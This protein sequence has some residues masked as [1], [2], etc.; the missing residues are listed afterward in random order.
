MSAALDEAMQGQGTEEL[1]EQQ[2][3]QVESQEG[4][5]STK[6]QQKEP[7]AK[8]ETAG[9]S[10]YQTQTEAEEEAEE[11][12]AKYKAKYLETLKQKALLDAGF[13]FGQ[14]PTYERYIS[15]ETV[16]EIEQQA[17]ELAT[18]VSKKPKYTDPSRKRSGWNPFK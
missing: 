7:G 3:E 18:E 2:G 6:S 12:Q 9:E 8:E 17:T 1:T 5:E 4:T 15:G 16:E 13:T 11:Q 14:L 10:Q